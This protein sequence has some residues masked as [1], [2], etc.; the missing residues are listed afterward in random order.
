MCGP[1]AKR[2]EAKN[3]KSTLQDHRSSGIILTPREV[4]E[5]HSH[6]RK[7][8]LRASWIFL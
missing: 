6:E 3:R 8:Q 4:T 5:Q 1:A 7:K 2:S